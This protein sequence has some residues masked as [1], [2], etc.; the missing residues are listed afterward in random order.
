[1]S[2]LVSAYCDAGLFHEA[3]K[4]L[5]QARALRPH[6]TG[7]LNV[8]R[9]RW[10]EGSVD[11]GLNRH[12][13]AARTFEEVRNG[14]LEANRGFDSALVSLELAATRLAQ[15]RPDEAESVLGEAI[16]M[17]VALRVEREALVAL[18]TL[19]TVCEA[20]QATQAMI[21]EVASF[22][23]RFVPDPGMKAG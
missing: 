9:A 22:I 17:F 16:Q 12:E 14:F 1:M 11:A 18:I 6:A 20:R 4:A 10:Q 23:R 7:K 19:R 5:F 2:N 21:L 15:G 13:R 8:L 3:E